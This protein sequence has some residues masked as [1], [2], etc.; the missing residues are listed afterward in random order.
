M[1]VRHRPS[2]ASSVHALLRMDVGS[3]VSRAGFTG[4]QWVLVSAVPS[5]GVGGPA[6]TLGGP[7]IE[8]MIVMGLAPVGEIH[9]CIEVAV[10]A[11]TAAAGEHPV[12]EGQCGVDGPALRA[13]ERSKPVGVWMVCVKRRQGVW[14]SGSLR[15]TPPHPAWAS[16]TN[17]KTSGSW[18]P[19]IHANRTSLGA[20]SVMGTLATSARW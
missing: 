6:F 16:S 18:R 2:R 3:R 4:T 10:S 17:S 5:A 9:R 19:A 11:M 7:G 1:V 15:P 8:V 20:M 12:R 14:V 13:D